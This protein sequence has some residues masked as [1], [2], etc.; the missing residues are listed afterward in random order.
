MK[1]I[2]YRGTTVE[3]EDWVN[4]VATDQDGA[5]W[6]FENIP[7]KDADEWINIDGNIAPVDMCVLHWEQ[8]LEKV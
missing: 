5:V 3:V 1:Q 6:L 8:S 2:N 4:Y 7:Y